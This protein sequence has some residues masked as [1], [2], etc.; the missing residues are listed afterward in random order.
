MLERK[1][2]REI[3]KEAMKT[4]KMGTEAGD[5]R[6]DTDKWRNRGV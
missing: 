4:G 1:N 5:R 6:N 2:D 3:E